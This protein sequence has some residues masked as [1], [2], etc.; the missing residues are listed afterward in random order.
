MTNRFERFINEHQGKLEAALERWLPVSSQLGAEALNEALRYAVFPGGKRLRP[1]LTLVATKLVGGDLEKALPAAC[2]IE[3][4]HT[5]SLVLDDLPAM[6]DAD[7]RRGR[8]S[9]HL[10]WGEDVTL[11]AALALLNQ[12]YALLAHAAVENGAPASISDLIAEVTSCIGSEGM[13]GGQAVDLGPRATVASAFLASRNLKTTSLMRLTLTAG[14]IASGAC[15]AD[16]AALA[17]FGECLGATYQVYDDLLD[18][19]GDRHATG[20]TARQDARHRRVSFVKELGVEGARRLAIELAEE[21]E[22]TISRRFGH[23]EE[24][25]LLIEAMNLLIHDIQKLAPQTVKAGI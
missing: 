6:D 18:E 14:A 7:W 25:R 10:V 19:F 17:R 23:R 11:L 20:K 24:A 9:T 13:I 22:E 8:R 1:V 21:G 16:A 4:L 5:S 2:A 15:K 3:F 12:S